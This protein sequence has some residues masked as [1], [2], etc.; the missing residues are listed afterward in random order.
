VQAL[1]DR[2][3]EVILFGHTHLARDVGVGPARYLNTGTW[4]DFLRFPDEILAGPPEE[5]LARLEQF[6]TPLRS[7]RAFESALVRGDLGASLVFRPTYARLDFGEG[8]RLL[9]ASLCDFCSPETV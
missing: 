8:D 4:A 7:R 6:V 1:A 3:F 2:G 9:R 5:A